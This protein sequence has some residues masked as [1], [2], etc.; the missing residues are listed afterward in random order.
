MYLIPGRVFDPVEWDHIMVVD[1][2]HIETS[3]YLGLIDIEIG[4]VSQLM[5]DMGKERRRLSLMTRRR[6]LAGGRHRVVI[7]K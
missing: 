3:K 1:K 2:G 5:G 6:A 4:G 7:S